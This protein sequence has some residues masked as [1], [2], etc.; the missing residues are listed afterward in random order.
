MLTR[1]SPHQFDRHLQMTDKIGFATGHVSW[2]STCSSYHPLPLSL[3]LSLSPSLSLPLCVSVSILVSASLCVANVLLGAGIPREHRN[4]V[5]GV[6]MA[7][8]ST[9]AND[10][11]CSLSGRLP[12]SAFLFYTHLVGD[13]F[14]CC[15]SLVFLLLLLLLLLLLR[16]LLLLLLLLLLCAGF[17]GFCSRRVVSLSHWCLAGWLVS[18]RSWNPSAGRSY[19]DY[20]SRVVRTSEILA[21][22]LGR[23][24]PGPPSPPVPPPPCAKPDY[25]IHT[26]ILAVLVYGWLLRAKP[27]LPG[28]VWCASA[29]GSPSLRSQA[30][31]GIQGNAGTKKGLT[32]LGLSATARSLS[33]I[34]RRCVSSR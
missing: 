10:T 18:D 25:S 3:S 34:A 1:R 19:A 23:A 20:Q 21:A 30:L 27:R 15:W 12:A 29:A 11:L 6:K 14:C 32:E 2:W 4:Q 26:I 28:Y 8:W 9:D 5:I 13:S 16:L 17:C 22:L 7:V 31:S 33:T 24:A